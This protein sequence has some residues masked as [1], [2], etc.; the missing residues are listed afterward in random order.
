MQSAR[1]TVTERGRAARAALDDT[2]AL[3][4]LRRLVRSVDVNAPPATHVIF[5][6]QPLSDVRRVGLFAGSF[7]PLTRAHLAIGEAA[8]Q[9]AALDAVVWGLAAVTVDKEHVERASM[10]DRLAQ[11]QVYVGTTST[12]ALAVFNRGL[13]VD[14]AAAL[15]S[16][17][18]RDVMLSILV[19]FDK[20]VQIFDPRYYADRDAALRE[21]FALAHLLVAPR[22]G[23]GAEALAELLGRPENRPFARFVALVPMEPAFTDDSSTEARMLAATLPL[24]VPSLR[25]LLPPEGMALA[26]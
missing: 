4:R 6:S 11:M 9:V 10:A 23:L 16:H 1:P 17:L 21:L 14:E 24:P 25:R 18:A 3:V 13:Y 26:R 7:N 22:A 2:A 20:I 5:A 15:R 8:R 12:D 19:G